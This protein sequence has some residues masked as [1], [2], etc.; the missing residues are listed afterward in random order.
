MSTNNYSYCT[1]MFF[2]DEGTLVYPR[3]GKDWIKHIT[4]ARDIDVYDNED[5]YKNIREEYF[6]Q[7][8]TD[9]L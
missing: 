3:C 4:F 7:K 6:I 5:Y 1:E 9:N 2:V 8:K